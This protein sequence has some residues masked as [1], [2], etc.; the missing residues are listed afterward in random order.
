[1]NKTKK[2]EG[3]PQHDKDRQPRDRPRLGQAVGKYTH[4]VVGLFFFL[5]HSWYLV[6]FVSL[7]TRFTTRAT[8]LSYPPGVY[9]TAGS[10]CWVPS[11]CRSV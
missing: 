7:G 8:G 10:L 1:M 9:G 5:T 4:S 11:T 6:L 2:N 3:Y